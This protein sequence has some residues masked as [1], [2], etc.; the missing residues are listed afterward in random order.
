MRR[1]W[2]VLKEHR[3]LRLVLSAGLISLTGD[4]ILGIG[5]AYYVYVLTGTT[6]ASAMVLLAEFLPQLI[7]GSLV[8]VFVD[9]WNRTHTMVVTNL[10][11]AAGL[12]PLLLVNGADRVWIIYAVLVWE[13]TVQLFFAPAEQAMLPRLVADEDLVTANALNGQNRDLSRLVGSALGGVVVTAGGITALALVDALTF[14]VAAAMI[15]AVATSGARQPLQGHEGVANVA[16]GRLAKLR[17]EWIDGLRQAGSHRVL[18]VILVFALVTSVGEGIMGT[19][20]APFV[21]DV[22]HGSGQAYGIIVSVQA[23]G[24]I[25]GGLVA[26]SIGTRISTVHM[27][28]GAALVFGL[29]DLAMFLYPLIYVAIWPAALC[30]LVVGLPG[31]LTL[32]GFTTLFQRYTVDAYRGRVFSSMGVVQAVAAIT[33]TVGAGFLG[34]SVG[35]VPIIAIQGAGYVAAGAAV[36]LVLRGQLAPAPVVTT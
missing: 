30:M 17:R 27:F 15:A 21:R 18:R 8:G 7:L 11:L 3:D 9:R 12:F 35:I 5:L 23:V 22:L 34:D 29:I 25:V 33:G 24:G 1:L 4:W 19:L 26:A 14:V 28:G 36:L 16:T 31:A 13:G 20:F 10:L 2:A 32:A 6:L